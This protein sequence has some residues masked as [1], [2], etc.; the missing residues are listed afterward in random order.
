MHGLCLSVVL[1]SL[2][3]TVHYHRLLL[4]SPFTSCSAVETYKPS[5]SLMN[6][7]GSN[8]STESVVTPHSSMQ[9][10]S[11]VSA[12]KDCFLL[13]LKTNPSANSSRSNRQIVFLPLVFLFSGVMEMEPDLQTKH[14][15]STSRQVN[16]GV[17]Q[18]LRAEL[19][20]FHPASFLSTLHFV[21][22]C[23]DSQ[24]SS[25]PR[26]LVFVYS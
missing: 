24:V 2:C 10:S 17:S 7:C 5:T 16:C 25:T 19:P 22:S 23:N 26:A 12:T 18:S 15:G 14:V 9:R 21:F 13:P 3:N 4:I 1:H 11:A 8:R 20:S 6:L